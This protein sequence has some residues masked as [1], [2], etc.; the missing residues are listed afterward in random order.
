MKYICPECKTLEECFDEDLLVPLICPKCK[1][2]SFMYHKEVMMSKEKK[3]WKT[4]TVGIITALVL[5][6]NQ[7]VA[8]LDTDP[9]TKFSLAQVIAALG[10]LGIGWFARDNNKSSEDIGIK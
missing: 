4:S 10:A 9:E 8:I 5:I 6:L 1:K 2:I 3:S 7:I